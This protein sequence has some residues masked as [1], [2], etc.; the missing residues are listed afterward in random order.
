MADGDP[1][2]WGW[3]QNTTMR[4]RLDVW[5]SRKPITGTIPVSLAARTESRRSYPPTTSRTTSTPC[6]S[7][8][9]R[10]APAHGG[11]YEVGYLDELSGLIGQYNYINISCS[12]SKAGS[13][14]SRQ[15]SKEESP[16]ATWQRCPGSGPS[17]SLPAAGHDDRNRP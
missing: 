4:L 9:S 15:E 2:L 7:V 11:V 10:T 5:P 8:S 1:R 16:W 12:H 14:S 6:P 3:C 17:Y 13:S